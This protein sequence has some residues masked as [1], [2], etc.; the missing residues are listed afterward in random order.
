[1][2]N[3]IGFN[4]QFSN[5][6]THDSFPN[7]LA[8]VHAFFEGKGSDE[9]KYCNPNDENKRVCF[10]CGGCNNPE[11]ASV[12]FC[13]FDTMCGRSAVRLRFDGAP[14]RMAE[15]IGDAKDWLGKCATDYTTDFLLGFAGYD[16]R[17]SENPADFKNEI[18]A[19][20]DAGKPVIAECAAD[21]AGFRV[22][23]GYDGD[24][25]VCSH[26]A[27]DQGENKREMKTEVFTHDNFKALYIII[28]K[29][30]PRYTVA[31]GLERIKRVMENNLAEKVWDKGVGEITTTFVSSTDDE[32]RRMDPEV[33][34]TLRNRIA[35][36]M[37][38]RFNN[39]TFSVPFFNCHEFGMRDPAL[40]ELWGKVDDCC[41]RIGGYD[42]TVPRFYGDDFSNLGPFRTGYGR[43]FLSAIEE[44]NG[45]YA[46]ILELI[47]RAI[48]VLREKI[49]DRSQT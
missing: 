14:T 15:M 20:V 23:T 11:P 47:N 24:D 42:H 7:C 25:V 41:G 40:A 28:G 36:T 43:M 33:L 19:S 44:L 2:K 34:K 3:S 30:T 5:L 4:I 26:Y 21:N 17:K 39:H 32:Y 9:P 29:I 8:G 12:Y 16:Y 49:Q 46:E 48:E 22:V 27:V 18:I 35:D 31:D 45:M 6:W 1:M 38:N 37:I 13:L 10:G